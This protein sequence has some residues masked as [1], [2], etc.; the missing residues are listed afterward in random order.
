MCNKITL[1]ENQISKWKR[2]YKHSV[3]KTQIFFRFIIKIVGWTRPLQFVYWVII[4]PSGSK[5][6]SSQ[7]E[8][9]SHYDAL[10]RTQET[11]RLMI[12]PTASSLFKIWTGVG[13]PMVRVLNMQKLQKGCFFFPFAISI[14]SKNFLYRQNILSA[15][16]SFFSCLTSAYYFIV[17]YFSF[18]I[19]VESNS[20]R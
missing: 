8:H 3:P 17:Q 4:L 15:T 16:Y 6:H 9:P 12:P 11:M 10:E 20:F 5:S 13:L 19:T 2:S 18:L 7:T 1:W 14:I